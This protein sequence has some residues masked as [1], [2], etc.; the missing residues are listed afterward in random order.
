MNVPEAIELF[1]IQ[2]KNEIYHYVSSEEL[3]EQL[4]SSVLE[5]EKAVLD[6]Y[7]AER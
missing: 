5:V 7:K 6:T 1:A 3:Q 2:M 4:I